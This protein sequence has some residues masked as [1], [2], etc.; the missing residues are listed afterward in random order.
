MALLFLG[1]LFMQMLSTDEHQCY[2]PTFTMEALERGGDILIGGLFPLHLHMSSHGLII[3]FTGTPR[4]TY[5]QKSTQPQKPLLNSPFGPASGDLSSHPSSLSFWFYKY[6]QTMI[7]AVEE[8]NQNPNLLPN[9]TLGFQIFDS[10][11]TVSRA[12]VGTMQFLT[13]RPKAIPNF[14]CRNHPPQAGIIGEAGITE[15]R[16][17]ARVLN[18]YWYS[19]ISYFA[20]GPVTNDGSRFPSFFRTLPSNKLQARGLA[21]LVIHFAW[22]WVGLLASDEEYGKQGIDI[23]QEEIAKRRVCV[24]F[25]HLLPTLPDAASIPRIIRSM[26]ESKARVIVTFCG[27]EALSLLLQLYQKG[28]AGRVWLCSEAISHISIFRNEKVWQMLSGSLVISTHKEQVPGLREFLLQLQPSPKDVFSQ[29]FWSKVFNCWWDTSAVKREGGARQCTGKE[30]LGDGNNAFLSMPGLGMSFNI[31]NAVY[32]IAHS[33]HNMAQEE[34]RG[35]KALVNKMQA[36]PWKLFQYL[37]KVHFKNTVGA[38]VSFDDHG[39]PPAIFDVLNTHFSNV[40]QVG[41]ITF[42]VSGA[43]D[44]KINNTAIRW[45]G[46]GTETPNSVCTPSCHPG[47]HKSHRSGEATCCFDCTPCAKGEISNQTGE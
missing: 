7:F 12:L 18:L 10:C 29:E 22:Q 36:S 24:A 25:S 16:T 38:E 13:G 23:V 5:C 4:S 32:A 15:S 43:E 41:Q 6:I 21:Q 37:R 42:S 19:Q 40:V 2:L 34:P 14:R 46:G 17:I 8:I 39:D 31:H 30:N 11:E 45:T 27:A 33:L 35:P 47:F 26:A 28:V 9:I 20:T 44:L 1:L 3:P